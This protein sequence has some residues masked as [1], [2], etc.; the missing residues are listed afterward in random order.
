MIAWAGL[1]VLLAFEKPLSKISSGLKPALS[2]SKAAGYTREHS[3]FDAP[4]LSLREK[5]NALNA[6]KDDP[7]LSKALLKEQPALKALLNDAS[8]KVALEKGE[9]GALLENPQLK[10]LLEDPELV[11]RLEG[12]G[13]ETK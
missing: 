6:L 13:A 7:K 4:V 10:K 1:S 3:L 11:K 2:A 12:L 8:L 5:L 9:T